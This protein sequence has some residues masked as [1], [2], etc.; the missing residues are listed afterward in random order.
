MSESTRR[1]GSSA[2]DRARTAFGEHFGE[3]PSFMVR[4]PGRVNLIGDHTDYS[5]GF[6]L[7]IAIDR[8]LWLAM[9]PRADRM[10]RIWAELGDEWAEID[11]DRLEIHRGWAAYVEGIAHELIV[12]G[13]ELV[14]FDGALT[15]D[16]PAG[17]G[18]SS[19]AALELAAAKAFSVSS[20]FAWDPRRA[21]IMGWRVENEWL[22]L[23]SGIMDQ[24]ICGSGHENHA[25]LIDCRNLTTRPVAIPTGTDVVVLDTGTR[26]KLTE[27]RYNERRLECE[28]ATAAY[29]K[30]F[31]RDLSLNTL[32][33]NPLSDWK[34]YRR[35]HHVVSENQRTIDAADALAGDDAALVGSLMV[36][37]HASLREDY[38]VSGPELDAMVEAA[39]A[40]PGCLGARMTGG[41]FAGCAVA[42]VESSALEGFISETTRVYRNRTGLEPSLYVCKASHGTSVETEENVT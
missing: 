28:A 36:S 18:L 11:L 22:G 5:E 15:S 20:G 1:V 19:S 17:A 31:L 42:L 30:E 10:V 27:S 6:V 40:A 16:L 4:S 25:L 21:A 38:E 33:S 34:L 26:R 7:P 41:G 35:A 8:G 3:P 23:S 9:R 37:S 2:Q 39:V 32:T 13:V 24:L 14:G 12:E 29:G